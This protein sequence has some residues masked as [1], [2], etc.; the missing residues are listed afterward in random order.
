M[1][2]DDW[3]WLALGLGVDGVLNDC[4]SLELTDRLGDCV[5]E[6]DCVCDT[7]GV[8]VMLDETVMLG[9]F[10]KLLVAL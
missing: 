9:D 8:T 2:E 7:L 6:F 5:C 1:T 4:V 10:V 3:L